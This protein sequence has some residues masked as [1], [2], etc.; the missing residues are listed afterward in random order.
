MSLAVKTLVGRAV[1]PKPQGEL[2]TAGIMV[3]ALCGHC[4]LQFLE[5]TGGQ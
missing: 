4:A 5:L 2:V 1:D 3:C